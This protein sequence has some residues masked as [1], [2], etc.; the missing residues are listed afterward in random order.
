MKKRSYLKIKF[1]VRRLC[2][3]SI[4][5]VS[6]TI[7]TY[8]QETEIFYL[9]G[10]GNDNT[11]PWEF[12]CSE[13]MNSQEWTTIQLPSCWEL[14]GFGSYN[15]GIDPWEDRLNEHGIYRHDFQLPEEWKGKKVNIVFEGVMTDAA[16]KINGKAAGAKHQGAFYEFKYDVS[17]LLNYGNK[18]NKIEVTVHKHSSDSLVNE[19]ER[20]A[21]YWVFGGIFR[22]VYL[23]VKPSDHIERI[24]ADAKANGDFKTNIYFDSPRAA[25]L[26]MELQELSGKK[27]ADLEEDI[28]D[29]SPGIISIS[30]H[31]EDIKSWNPE[32]PSLYQLVFKLMDK[33]HNILHQ[34]KVRIGFRSVEV[35]AKDGIYVNGVKVKFK[36][37]SRHVFW[38]TSGR[39]TSKNISISDVNLIKE[40]NMNAVRMSHYPPDKHF[41]DACDSL[42]LFVFDELAGWGPPAYGTEIGRKLVK[43]LVIRDENHPSIL[44]WGNG[45]EGG[46]NPDLDDDFS[47][48]DIQ[49][50]ETIRPR[51]IFRE[52][53]TL[54]YFKYNYLAYDSYQQDRIFITT[55]FLHGC[56]DEGHG[57]GLDDYWRMM[58]DNPI[59]AGGFLWNFSDE[60][61]VRTDLDN[62]LDVDGNHA[63]DGIT[64]P[65]R[66]KEGSF[67][68]VKE[69]WAPVHFEKKFITPSFEGNF[70]IENRYHFTNLDQCEFEA[71][72]IKFRG[73]D[74]LETTPLLVKAG[75]I[76]AIQLEPGEEGLLS[77]ELSDDWDSFDALYITAR[78]PH[79][80]EIFTWSFPVKG[81][82]NV[83]F[84]SKVTEVSAALK[85]DE[86]E[87]LILVRSRDIDFEFDKKTG[88]L[89]KAYTE[90]NKVLMNNGPRFI[91]QR[92]TDFS[93][94]NQY[95]DEHGNYI[96]EFSFQ[97]DISKFR[98]IQ[99]KIRWAV[100]TNG[101]LNLDVTGHYMQGITFDYPE[102][103]I[104]S[105][106]RLSDGPF[107]VWR[108]RMKGTTL[109]IWEDEYNNTITA[110]PASGYDYPEFKGF[111]SSL[112]W[113]R[114]KNKDQSSV[115]VYCH[116]PYTSLR[117]FTPETAESVREGWGTDAMEY[118]EGDLSF[119]NAILPIGTMF[120]KVEDLGPQS[121]PETVYGWD[122]EPY[123]MSLTF[124]FKK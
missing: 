6:C 75:H 108:N 102:D 65:A 124:D 53:N 7:L 95:F 109:G 71:Q 120:K 70:K 66:E 9:T 85:V 12:Y 91:T 110:D 88:V 92:E 121:Q 111:Y 87:Q 8:P 25:F 2:I 18:T 84:I 5:L 40:M 72:W 58:W 3:I 31:F 55:E 56:W 36:G 116:T 11:V 10:T 82:G 67:Y 46:W 122:S 13:G 34:T 20:W 68:T 104:H 78:D 37:I 30:T 38:P 98:N 106:K 60:A 41:L 77:L 35:R 79:E 24:S 62:T 32:F 29:P 17:K 49:Q 73:P 123:S 42:G 86:T 61:I 69:I 107:R 83:D 89:S 14:Q 101:L 114:L 96:L 64:G 4:I 80:K 118:Y 52:I 74:D 22:P 103:K 28:L 16:V 39:T 93:G 57:A 43:E 51:Q 33:H 94:L 90:E 105:V 117:L 45:N 113:T 21:D 97:G 27:I 54:H 99:Y 112:Y 100:R 47:I 81:P 48:W 44:F 26:G 63:A 76:P 50:R 19:A 23:E 59:C 119:L 115:T 15:Y 1:L